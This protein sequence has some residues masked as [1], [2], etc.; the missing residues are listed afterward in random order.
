MISATHTHTQYSLFLAIR[1][2]VIN[3]VVFITI[4]HCNRE[5][6]LVVQKSTRCQTDKGL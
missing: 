3:T 1:L 4:I 5:Y 6:T 2:F